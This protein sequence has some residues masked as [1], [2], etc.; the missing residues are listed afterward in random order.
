MQQAL[1]KR[2]E[3]VPLPETPVNREKDGIWIIDADSKTI[4][5]NGGMAE[6]LLTSPAEMMGRSA[7]IYVFPEDLDSAKRLFEFKKGGDA[8]SFQFRLCRQ[9]GSP[10][11]VD[12]QGTPMHSPIGRFT[13]IV[14]TFRKIEKHKP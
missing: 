6:I 10:V 7:F 11:W 1:R 4:Y 3:R 14:G 13:G 9:D 5:A 12:V 8:N 2:V